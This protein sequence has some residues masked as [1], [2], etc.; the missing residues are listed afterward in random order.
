[1][2]VLLDKCLLFLLCAAVLARS[3]GG[4]ETALVAFTALGISAGAQCVAPKPPKIVLECC[5]CLLCAF[6]PAALTAIALPAYEALRT[7]DY[8]PLGLYATTFFAIAVNEQGNILATVLLTTA[9][10][11]LCIT[12]E[13][14]EKYKELYRQT[15]D[16]SVEL[17]NLLKRRNAE[18]Y[19]NQ[20][21]QVRVAT[22]HERNRIARE[23]HDNVGHMLS[24]SLLQV[25]A[26]IAVEKTKPESTTLSSLENLRETLD[27]A[28]NSIRS[29][30][31][32]LRDESLDLRQMLTE[33]LKPMREKYKITL[34]YAV[35]EL[36]PQVKIC[37]ISII[38]EAVSNIVRHSD[39][40]A[41]T[42]ILREHPALFQ[43]IIRDNGTP[44]RF[45][46]GMGISGMRDRAEGIGGILRVSSDKGFSVFVSL[47]K[48]GVGV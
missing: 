8:I 14:T 46:E 42:V 6:V 13:K 15:R 10:V 39:A 5:Y 20:E 27:L 47:K 34:D 17:N 24:R 3:S 16:S 43:L 26:L 48:E 38:K 21:N 2:R 1:M 32:D 37:F 41:F 4:F 28:M 40:D 9:A 33:T 12:K 18:L 44:C 30:V 35:E 23:I 31:H 22:L 19:E 45:S 11:Y 29:S 25:G 36:P 7:R